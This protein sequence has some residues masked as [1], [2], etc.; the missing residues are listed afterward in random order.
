MAK[1][2]ALITGTG[3]VTINGEVVS[4][5]GVIAVRPL[6]VY[7][8]SMI[9]GPGAGSAILHDTADATGTAPAVRLRTA[10]WGDQNRARFDGAQ[11]SNGLRVEVI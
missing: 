8:V 5:A 11:F 1:T 2:L 7:S 4:T 10:A 3:T 9:G 6:T